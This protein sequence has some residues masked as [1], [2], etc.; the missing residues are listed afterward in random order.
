MTYPTDRPT[1]VWLRITRWAL[2]HTVRA[3]ESADDQLRTPWLREARTLLTR[4]EET[5]WGTARPL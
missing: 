1:R 4:C 3:A 5:P 2:A